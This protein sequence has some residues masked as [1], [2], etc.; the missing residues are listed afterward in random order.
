MRYAI[1]RLLHQPGFSLVV[2]ATL[3]LGIGANTAMFSLVNA[4]LL[5]PLPYD[6]PERL[7]TINHYYPSLNNLEAGFAVPTYRDIR[8][9]TPIF[10][11]F[12]VTQGWNVN[13]TGTGDPERLAGNRVTADFFRVFGVRPMVGRTFVAGEDHAGRERVAVLSHG[14]WMRR[15]GGD[16]SIVGR[17]IQ[18]DG[19]PYDVIGVMPAFTASSTGAW[20][21]GRP[22]CSPRNSL[23]TADARASFSPPWAA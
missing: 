14:L 10:E 15:F 2:I 17:K 4:V 13:L 18:L 22:S 1:R 9:Q 19:E 11:A 20:R 23:P 5:T 3:A 7:V 8:E 16:R 21:S 12:A 6:E